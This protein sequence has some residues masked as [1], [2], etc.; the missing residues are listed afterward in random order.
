MAGM[1]RTKH[2]IARNLGKRVHRQNDCD[3]LTVD[4][5][6]LGDNDPRGLYTQLLSTTRVVLEV[7]LREPHATAQCVACYN[8][9]LL[10]G[11]T[12]R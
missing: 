4:K 2:T 10:S 12:A 5:H 11:L 9:R 1:C 3:T 7:L 6:A 8:H